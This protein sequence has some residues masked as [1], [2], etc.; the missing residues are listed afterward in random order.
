MDDWKWFNESSLPEKEGLC[1]NFNMEDITDSDNYHAKTI[2]K[3]FEIKFLDQYQ[4]WSLKHDTL[5]K[6]FERFRNM[7]SKNMTYFHKNLFCPTN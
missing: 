3:Y 1:S 7:Y 5:L 6:P 4:N 2:C